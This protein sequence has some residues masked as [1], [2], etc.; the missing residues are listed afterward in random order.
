MKHL[1]TILLAVGSVLVSGTAVRAGLLNEDLEAYWTLDETSGN[2]V[3][4]INGNVGTP[5]GNPHGDGSNGVIGGA[6]SLSGSSD[7][8]TVPHDPSIDFGTESFAV[9]LWLDG[10]NVSNDDRFIQKG[11]YGGS[12]GGS[13]KRY[14]LSYKNNTM[15]FAVDDDSTKSVL[16]TSAAPFL[17]GDFVHVAAVRDTA[18]GLLKLYAN[19]TLVDTEPDNTGSI[20][21]TERLTIANSYLSDQG[22]AGRLDDVALFGR[23]LMPGEVA[24]LASGQSPNQA[25]VVVPEPSSVVLAALGLL[26]LVWA[27]RRRR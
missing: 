10:D 23:A 4:L 5:Q 17:T 13:G 8:V 11:T 3:D 16:H 2:F 22:F 1:A 26:G 21:Q 18:D 24:F 9:S 12:S 20:S 27:A 25:V 15:R 7:Y 6:L 14:E 19:G